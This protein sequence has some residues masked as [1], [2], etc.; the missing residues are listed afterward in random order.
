MKE[1]THRQ[2]QL[3]DLIAECWRT[4]QAPV[5]MELARQM[6]LT[7][8]PSLTPILKALEKKGYI[9]VQGGVRGRQ[10]LIRL[11]AKGKVA[12]HRPGLPV[13][14]CIPAGPLS[15]VLQ[16][17][18][19]FVEGLDDVLPYKPGDFLLR[20]QGDSMSGDGIYDG[21]KVLLRPHVQVNS[22][23]IAAVHVGEDYCA[24]LKHVYF[25]P[26][27]KTVELRASNPQ[28]PPIV[29]PAHEVR[30]VG[31]FRGLVRSCNRDGDAN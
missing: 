29:K 21:D 27:K 18:E 7:A 6:G 13:L 16:E 11:T 3:L 31:V 24:T 4:E 2:R 20:V 30:I 17:A 25:K 19:V 8:E 23:E 14:G 5:V 1:L 26:N 28:Y 9:S 15:E 10:R 12:T 22:G